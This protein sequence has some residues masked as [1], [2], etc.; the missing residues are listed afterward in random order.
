MLINAVRAYKK[1]EKFERLL[2]I[3]KNNYRQLGG[4]LEEDQL[5]QKDKKEAERYL[6]APCWY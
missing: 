3:A 1:I 4:M 6:S 5:Q 2:E